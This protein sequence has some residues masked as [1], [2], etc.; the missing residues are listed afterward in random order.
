MQI[1]EY[2]P[3][4]NYLDVLLHH[5]DKLYSVYSVFSLWK[6][7]K[8]QTGAA[9]SIKGQTAVWIQ[10]L[11][12]VHQKFNDQKQHSGQQL[13]SLAHTGSEHT[14]HARIGLISHLRKL[15]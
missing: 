15:R 8:D 7:W 4:M 13:Q 12:E 11:C 5:E 3:I 1:A 2:F 14:S 10:W 9:Q 6:L